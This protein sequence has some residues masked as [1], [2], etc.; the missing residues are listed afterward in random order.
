MIKRVARQKVPGLGGSFWQAAACFDL[1]ILSLSVGARCH[2]PYEM[3]GVRP[4]IKKLLC[5]IR[6]RQLEVLK[7]F[8]R[9]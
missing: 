9:R 7:V 4:C 2:F 1:Q 3:G 8:K 5:T 6:D